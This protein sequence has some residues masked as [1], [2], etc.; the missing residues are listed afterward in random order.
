MKI[1]SSLTPNET[2][3]DAAAPAS[4]A[5]GLFRK[6]REEVYREIGMRTINPTK[7]EAQLLRESIERA[8]GDF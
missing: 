4:R 2:G 1:H 3:A 5:E 7:I 6:Q 8:N